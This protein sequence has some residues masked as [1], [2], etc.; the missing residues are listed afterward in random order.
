MSKPRGLA[1]LITNRRT[2]NDLLQL[3]FALM[4]NLHF[5][6]NEPGSAVGH[7]AVGM[8]TDVDVGRVVRPAFL[9]DGADAAEA[10]KI[11]FALLLALQFQRQTTARQL[12]QRDSRMTRV[13]TAGA[14]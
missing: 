7:V 3:E 6:L 2:V 13:A 10:S 5:A 8:P 14:C 4:R 1:D 12:S 9:R 11:K